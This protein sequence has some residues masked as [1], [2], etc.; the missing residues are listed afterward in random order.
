MKSIIITGATSG[1]GFEC[2]RHTASIAPG[3][4]IVIACR[5]VKSGENTIQA[6]AHETGHPNL[7]CMPLD[8]NSLASVRNFRD[9]FSKSSCPCIIALINNAG[10]QNISQTQI[11]EEGFES[12]F[13]VNHLAPLY[14]T[15]LLMPFMDSKA[16]ITFTASGVH[17]PKQK[18]GI[19]HPVFKSAR[20][21]AY[22]AE[23]E[24]KLHI[25]GQRRYSTSKLCNILT[26][27][28]LQRRL[29]NTAIRVNAFDPGL[30]PGTG[31]A[32]TYSPLMRFLWRNVF[33][34][35]KYFVHNINTAENSGK[36]LANLAYSE[37]YKESKGKY[38]EGAKEI[39]SSI[40]SY[41]E[42]FQHTLWKTSVELL[43]IKQEETSVL[44]A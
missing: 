1:I 38:F 18:T 9:Q 7:V 37:D 40:D 19:E 41:N 17:D 21:L 16:S 34:L 4:Q 26:S 2:A 5:D 11:T 32:R 33:P 12:T 28:E 35:L 42:D 24:E 23:M 15:L 30:V 39:R 13:G 20:E 44:L 29:S 36:R 27:Y 8:L 31:L 6:I 10:I 22:P 14:L 3:E 43:G 25:A